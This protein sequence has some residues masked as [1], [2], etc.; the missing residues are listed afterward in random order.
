[1]STMASQIIGFPILYSTVCSGADQRKHQ[2]FVSLAF[3]TVSLAC[4][5]KVMFCGNIAGVSQSNLFQT[6]IYH[7]SRDH[8]VSAPSQWET[9]LH[10]NV[11]SHWLGAY[12]KW[13][14]WHNF[15]LNRWVLYLRYSCRSTYPRLGSGPQLPTRCTTADHNTC[16]DDG[17]LPQLPRFTL[18]SA[19]SKDLWPKLEKLT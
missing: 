6:I 4:V 5:R 11:V 14:L 17:M 16:S 13:F 3:L 9:T 10:C 7:D 1:M 18:I 12:T 15:F 8:F 19:L 2:R